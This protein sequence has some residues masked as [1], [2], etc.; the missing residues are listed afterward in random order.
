MTNGIALLSLKDFLNNGVTCLDCGGK[1][2]V[3]TSEPKLLIGGGM[4]YSAHC[5]A[6]RTPDG[7]I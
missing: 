4:R 5:P 2:T 7:C 6:S 3:A 1:V